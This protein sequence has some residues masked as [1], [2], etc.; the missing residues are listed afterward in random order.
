VPDVRVWKSRHDCSAGDNGARVWQSASELIASGE[1]ADAAAVLLVDA[2][3]S[4]RVSELRDLPEH[5][6]VVATDADAERALAGRVD[7]SLADAPPEARDCVLDVACRLAATRLSAVRLSDRLDLADREARELSHVSSKLMLE[8]DR[9]SLLNLILDTGKRLTQSDGIGLLLVKP[10]VRT[11]EYEETG[12]V[13]YLYPVAYSFGVAFP[14]PPT[15]R[16]AID[17]TTIVGHAAK[18]KETVVLADAH[19]LPPGAVFMASKEIESRFRYWVRPMMVVPMLDH[20]NRVLGVIFFVNRRSDP[21]AT[22]RTKEDAERYTQP[23]TDREVNVARALASQAALSIENARLYVRIERIFENFIKAAVGAI[24][25]R[26]PTTAGHSLRVA[27]LATGLAEA[28]SRADGRF[29]DVKFTPDQIRELRFAALLHDIGKIAVREDVLMKAKKLP[30]AL[31]ERV[32]ARFDLI[33]SVMQT[34]HY[35]RVLETSGEHGSAEARAAELAPELAARLEE[36]ERQRNVVRAAN[37][38][39]IVGRPP[40]KELLEIAA[41][42]FDWPEGARTPYLTAE[43]VHYLQVSPGTLDER[44]RAQIESHVDETNRLLTGIPWTDDL[45]NLVTYAYGHHE[46]LNGSGYPRKLQGDDIPIQTRIITMADI[47]DALTEA[48]RP[49]KPAVPPEKALEIMEAEATAGLLDPDLLRVMIDSEVY[50]H[51][52]T[53]PS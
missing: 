24:D 38:P 16:F 19:A 52:E 5:V 14:Q 15:M 42:T 44:E 41:R 48:D 6:V 37:E 31:W 43:E 47:Y 8:H 13:E 22:I 26:D 33:R 34:E 18:I 3:T 45:K 46:K 21:S 39:T 23:Y 2:S 7:V 32:D 36:L 29:R 20:L 12:N 53:D 9:T 40:E 28:V 27:A 51:I 50:L 4:E 17:D 11:G 10:D 35:K 1:G 49:Y 25:M 30:T